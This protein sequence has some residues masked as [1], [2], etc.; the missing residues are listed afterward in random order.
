MGETISYGR[1]DALEIPLLFGIVSS[2][3]YQG[4]IFFLR[5]GT[6]DGEGWDYK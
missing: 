5:G 3:A 1:A 6:K 2:S 4:N